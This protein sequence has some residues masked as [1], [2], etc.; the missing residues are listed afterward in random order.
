MPFN[1][2]HSFTALIQ[3]HFLVA[4]LVIFIGIFLEGEFVLIITGVLAHLHVLPV[5]DI[6]I[7]AFLAAAMKS[8]VGYYIGMVLAK[9]YPSSRILKFIK[10]KVLSFLPK[11]REKPFWSIFGSKFIYGVNHFSI[12]FAGYIKANFNLYIRAEMLA[13]ILWVP[14]LFCLGY[15]FS[16]TAFGISHDIRKAT[17]IILLLV[18]GFIMLQKLVNVIIE[19]IEEKSHEEHGNI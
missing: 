7:I 2:V 15:F 9:K 18:I 12:I 4:L 8:F 3:A 5:V 16:F 1:F 11:F 14:L 6:L 10:H 13:N 17:I 19:A